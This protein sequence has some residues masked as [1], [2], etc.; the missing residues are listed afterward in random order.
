MRR[1]AAVSRLGRLPDRSPCPSTRL[2]RKTAPV[3]IEVSGS[4]EVPRKLY[5]VVHTGAETHTMPCDWHQRS[6]QAVHHRPA[7][8]GKDHRARDKRVPLRAHPVERRS[9]PAHAPHEPPQASCRARHRQLPGRSRR[10]GPRLPSR[11][12]SQASPPGSPDPRDPR[13]RPEA[14]I[15][16]RLHPSIWLHFGCTFCTAQCVSARLGVFAPPPKTQQNQRLSR[17]SVQN[18]QRGTEESNLEQG[19][20]RPPCYRYTSPPETL[21]LQ[22]LLQC[23]ERS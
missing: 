15:G 22:A 21:D 19:F 6:S 2:P 12:R 11:T 20:W 3:S 7:H 14:H 23:A 17:H 4:T 10:S 8:D 5:V 13:D 16:L 9:R 1:G 18:P